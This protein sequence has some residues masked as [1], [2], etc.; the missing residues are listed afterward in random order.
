VKWFKRFLAVLL[1][2]ALVLVIL[3]ALIT[4][5]V[6]N[7]L[8]KSQFIN[9]EL[10]QADV[11]NFV[12]D[13][14]MPLA[15]EEIDGNSQIPLD[16]AAM[17]PDIV[18]A[19]RKALPPEW[20]RQ[21]SE[22]LVN[23]VYPYLVGDTEAFSYTI[24]LQDRAEAAFTAIKED[25][26][27]GN[28]SAELYNSFLVYLSEAISDYA[29]ESFPEAGLTEA[30]VENWLKG[31]VS[32][33][34]LISQ[35]EGVLDEIKPYIEGDSEHFLIQLSSDIIT[36]EALLNIIGEGNEAYLDDV[37]E[38]INSKLTFTE[39]ELESLLGE[40]GSPVLN[41]VRHWIKDGYTLTE[42]DLS[43]ALAQ[44]PEDL[45]VF[46]NARHEI[47]TAR[48][49]LWA[50]WLP[51]VFLLV[52]IA[53]LGGES[54]KGRILWAIVPLFIISL[55]LYF[56]IGLF[57]SNT[58]SLFFHEIYNVSPLGDLENA[59]AAK[60]SEISGNVALDMINNLKMSSGGLA[61]LSGLGLL[62]FVAWSITNK[63]KEQQKPKRRS[64]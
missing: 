60:T 36:D 61:L 56:A 54:W 10:A 8:L 64:H 31:A 21:N 52:G 22:L 25:I 4:T 47:K 33:D 53:F 30:E 57:D 32:Q 9:E 1:C 39:T 45:T 18:S 55:A 2:A 17:A 6:N 11:Y 58:I 51:P 3:T 46:N 24:V 28:S 23:T 20:L 48:S 37:R 42:K 62:G 34:W 7:T 13:E 27:R 59:L 5:T 19:A 26:L 35:L 49:W 16:F 50:F 12:Y 43:L 44:T 63:R 40:E 41:D 14:A 38:V 29:A 15:L